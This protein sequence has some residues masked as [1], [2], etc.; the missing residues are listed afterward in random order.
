MIV[1]HRDVKFNGGKDMR[2]SLEMEFQLHGEE[3]IAQRKNLMMMWSSHMQRS[4]EWNHPLMQILTGMEGNGLER[5]T[6]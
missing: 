5:L 4:R 1:V 3:D 6:Y 2:C